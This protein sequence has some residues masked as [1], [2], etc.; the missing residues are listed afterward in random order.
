MVLTKI[1]EIAEIVKTMPD[2]KD[3]DEKNLV[4]ASNWQ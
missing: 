2:Q 1:A 3:L 4:Q